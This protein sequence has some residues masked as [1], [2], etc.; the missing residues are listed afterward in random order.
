[1]IE[2]IYYLS[3]EDLTEISFEEPYEWHENDNLVYTY[4]PE[5]YYFYI[6]AIE[7][8]YGDMAYSNGVIITIDEDGE[9]RMIDDY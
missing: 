1:M 3:D 7:D 4:L 5:G 6:F 9:I 2:P 8:V